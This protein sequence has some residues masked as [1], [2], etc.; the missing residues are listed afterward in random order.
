MS[1]ETV[2]AHAYSTDVE[3]GRVD[4]P[5]LAFT[6]PEQ[7][8]FRWIDSLA[9]P[10]DAPNAKA[11]N[12]F[13]EMYLQPK[14]S[15]QNSTVVKIDTGNEPAR[16]FIPADVLDNPVI[17]PPADQLDALVFTEP[18][19]DAQKTYDDAWQRVQSS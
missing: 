9:I 8:G 15:A 13:V 7:G 12:T 6:I 11:A 16:Q 4:N 19:G 3:Q 17:F 14:T 5:K 1:G 2:C 10:Q 18:V